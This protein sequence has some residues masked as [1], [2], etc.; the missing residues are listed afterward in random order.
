[1][2]VDDPSGTTV[3]GPQGARPARPGERH[4]LDALAEALSRSTGAPAEMRIGFAGADDP[5]AAVVIHRSM[6]DRLLGEPRLRDA[7]S[8]TAVIDV[9]REAVVAMLELQ[10][11]GAVVEA[12][13]YWKWRTGGVAD[14]AVYGD[15]SV[16]PSLTR[17][18][19]V[20]PLGDG[21]YGRI[22]IDGPDLP[23]L[24]GEYLSARV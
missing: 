11:V 9:P 24:L 18:V 19:E 2:L 7:V 22:R 1:V 10:G 14:A 15:L 16:V 3:S 5:G 6:L 12:N 4:D 13:Q 17:A 8:R 23:G 21:G 20:V